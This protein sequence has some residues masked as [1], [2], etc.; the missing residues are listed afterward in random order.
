MITRDAQPWIERYGSGSLRQAH[1]LGMSWREMYLHERVALEVATSARLVHSSRLTTGTFR[2]E[3]DDRVTTELGWYAKAFKFRWGLMGAPYNTAQAVVTWF[4]LDTDGESEQG[5]GF[6][7]LG[8]DFPWFPG[9]RTVLIPLAL[10][11]TKAKAWGPVEN[12][13]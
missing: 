10:W 4:T 6:V 3:P 9:G 12:P 5:A 7:V 13:L 1:A 2:A 11:D 8:L